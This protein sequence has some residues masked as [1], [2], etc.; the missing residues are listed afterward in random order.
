[1][2]AILLL[3]DPED[4]VNRAE[5]TETVAQKAL[6]KAMPAR[7]TVPV[8]HKAQKDELL[9]HLETPQL[10]PGLQRPKMH[11]PIPHPRHREGKM[12]TPR[13]I[14]LLIPEANLEN[15]RDVILQ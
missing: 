11:H 1:M 12:K 7:V 14:K 5:L 6:P 15:Q 9:V 2:A 4:A 3:A 13:V 10:F 8:K